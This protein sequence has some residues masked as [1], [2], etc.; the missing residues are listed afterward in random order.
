MYNRF[1]K[2]F[3]KSSLFY[4]HQFGFHAN[5]STVLALIFMVYKIKKAI[6]SKNYSCHIFIDLTKAFGTVDH[7]IIFT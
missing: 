6:D 3:G 7:H 1:V 4:D 2:Y 5:H